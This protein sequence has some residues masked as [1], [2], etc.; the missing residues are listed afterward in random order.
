MGTNISETSIVG[1]NDSSHPVFNKNLLYQIGI[2]VILILTCLIVFIACTLM[3]RATKNRLKRQASAL[4]GNNECVLTNYKSSTTEDERFSYSMKNAQFTRRFSEIS[5]E[6]RLSTF[7]V[8]NTF[9]SFKKGFT[10]IPKRDDKLIKSLNKKRYVNTNT[11]VISE[12]GS[13]Q[14]HIYAVP[15]L[16]LGKEISDRLEKLKVNTRVSTVT[17]THDTDTDF[18][19]HALCERELRII[20]PEFRMKGRECYEALNVSTEE[21][22]Y[23]TLTLVDETEEEENRSLYITPIF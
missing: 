15:D 18:T 1:N 10:G 6:T 3:W 7:H 19:Q 13:A 22:H 4:P 12:N 9:N 17:D 5:N 21:R 23:E 14:F 8:Y 11:S 16:M 2:L 20:S